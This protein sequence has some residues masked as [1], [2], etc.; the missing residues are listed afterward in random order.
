MG[1]MRKRALLA[2]ISG[3]DD[4]V[5]LGAML[6]GFKAL[7]GSSLA[8][9]VSTSATDYS[10]VVKGYQRDGE[11]TD[12]SEQRAAQLRVPCECNLLGL[13]CLCSVVHTQQLP[14][15]ALSVVACLTAYPTSAASC[16]LLLQQSALQAKALHKPSLPDGCMLWP[17]G[18]WHGHLLPQ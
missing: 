12:V 6:K 10:N 4:N 8:P 11:L 5:D 3:A 14:S 2:T 17:A 7:A 9:L 16:M 18:Y 1:V 15:G 13:L